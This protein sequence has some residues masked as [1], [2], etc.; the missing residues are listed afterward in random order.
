[1][2]AAVAD[3]GTTSTELARS[4]AAVVVPS[5]EPPALLEMVEAVAST[6]AWAAQLGRNGQIHARHHLTM[7]DAMKR[8][9]QLLSF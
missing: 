3:N 8:L 9:D 4:Q 7:S 6:P 2:V 5:G 1:V